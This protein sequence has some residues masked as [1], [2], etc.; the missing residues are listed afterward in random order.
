ME[1]YL[2]DFG[3][4]ISGIAIIKVTAADHNRAKKAAAKQAGLA[5]KFPSYE[6]QGRGSAHKV[7]K[8]HGGGRKRKGCAIREGFYL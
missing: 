4:V 8:R 5:G 1:D 7:S 6:L 3:K 2:V